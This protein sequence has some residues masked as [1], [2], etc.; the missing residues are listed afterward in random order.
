MNQSAHDRGPLDHPHV[1]T[2]PWPPVAALGIVLLAFGL[3]LSFSFKAIG[4]AILMIGT[5]VTLLGTIGW[6]RDLIKEANTHTLLTAHAAS[7]VHKPGQDMKLAMILFIASEIMFFAAF[8]GFY[9]YT[10]AGAKVWPPEGT[11]EVIESLLLP[12]IQTVILVI[13]SFTYTYAE[14]ALMRDNRKGLVTGLA[15]TLALG[16][17][18]ISGQAYEW[19]H[20]HLGITDG[21]LGAAF[22]MLTGFHGLHVI[23]GAIFILVNLV[24]AI[25]GDFTKTDH[26]ALQGAGWYWHFVDVVWL[27]L[28]FVVLY[29]PLY[30]LR[31]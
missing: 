9:F 13:S 20:M 31:G 30:N 18:F 23:V 14:S 8:F 2:N 10:S 16:A 25:K 12:A 26:F 7:A 17:I 15:I 5:I 6:W 29:V 11:P 24:R 4:Y 27:I 3:A 19:R 28:F 22:F 21:Q 1:D